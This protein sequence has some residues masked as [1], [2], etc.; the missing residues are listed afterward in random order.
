[1][2]LSVIYKNGTRTTPRD[3]VITTRSSFTFLF[4]LS[5]KE[6]AEFGNQPSMYHYQKYKNAVGYKYYTTLGS[7][8]LVSMFVFTIRSDLKVDRSTI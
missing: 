3:V 8:S 2:I 1:M 4:R 7:S 6:L 5:H